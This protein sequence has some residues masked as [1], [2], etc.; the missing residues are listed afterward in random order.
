MYVEHCHL[1]LFNAVGYVQGVC[2]CVSKLA[3][4]FFEKKTM[5]Y[6]F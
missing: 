1:L 3:E 6:H 2:V 4:Y 5:S